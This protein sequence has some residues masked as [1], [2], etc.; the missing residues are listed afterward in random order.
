MAKDFFKHVASH[1]PPEVMEQAEVR[2]Q[3]LR[4]ELLLKELRES[5]KVTQEQMS[6]RTGI[7]TPN[8]SRL[9][10][11]SDMQ[12]ATLRKIIG[13]LGGKLEIIARFDKTAVRIALP[14]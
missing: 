5:L 7:K 14:S 9:E 6:R 1:F 13:A 8:I 12:I 4:R 3:E 11:Q 2:Y 10:R